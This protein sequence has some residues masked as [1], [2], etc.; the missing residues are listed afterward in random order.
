MDNNRLIQEGDRFIVT[1]DLSTDGLSTWAAPFTGSFKCVIPK[2][3]VMIASEQV[4]G[5]LGFCAIPENY[6]DLEPQVV[7]QADRSH[8]KYTGYYFV[9]LTQAI[10]NTLA[11]HPD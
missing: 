7:P 11:V 10:G 4:P 3:T 9:F 5:A 2:G 8:R 1:Q 6:H